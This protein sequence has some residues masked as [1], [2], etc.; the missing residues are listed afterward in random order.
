MREMLQQLWKV[1]DE[2]PEHVIIGGI[3]ATLMGSPRTTAD[4]DIVLMLPPQEA[5]QIVTL[6]EHYGFHPGPGAT[7]KLSAGR[8]AKFAFSRRFSVDV[9]LASFSLDSAAIRRAQKI[10]LF[11]YP[12]RIATPEDLI[13]YKL[14][15]WDAIDQAD[16]R[17]LLRRVSGSLDTAYLEDQI[18]VL[19]QE[20][21]LPTLMERWH[22]IEP[23]QETE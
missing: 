5:E 9:R 1:L 4:V 3:A 7:A 18:H 11:G 13:V 20:A 16:V 6:C 19:M 12:L 10:P 8:P 14:A 22:S 21:G 17:H 23:D 2:F 15:R